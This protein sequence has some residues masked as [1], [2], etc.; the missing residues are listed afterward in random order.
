[1]RSRVGT[2]E[3]AVHRM[4][5]SGEIDGWL[6]LLAVLRARMDQDAPPLRVLHA[7]SPE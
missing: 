6:G 3:S 7:G 2:V 5:R 4:V 1:V